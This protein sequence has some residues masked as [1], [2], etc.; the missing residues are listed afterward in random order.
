MGHRRRSRSDEA[1]LHQSLPL[2]HSTQS[3]KLSG[4]PGIRDEERSSTEGA[5]ATGDGA[6][7]PPFPALPN[8]HQNYFALDGFTSM[9]PGHAS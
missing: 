8:R 2:R 6:A 5:Q 1:Q 3:N 7:I 9:T 4:A